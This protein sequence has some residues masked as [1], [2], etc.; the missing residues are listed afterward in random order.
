ML[1]KLSKQDQVVAYL[2]DYIEKHH[3]KSGD[4]L[5][6]EWELAEILNVSRTTIQGAFR[7]LVDNGMAYNKKGYG[8]YVNSAGK[9]ELSLPLVIADQRESTGGFEYVRGA[10]AYLKE[11]GGQL[12]TQCTNG[13]IEDEQRI[14]KDQ[15]EAGAKCILVL[16]ISSTKSGVFYQQ[17]ADQHGVRFIFLDKRPQG[18]NAD[19]VC[20][21]NVRGGYLAT[22]HLIKAGHTR[23]GFIS[24]SLYSAS[25]RM[26]RYIGYTMA[27]EAYGLT[28][29]PTMVCTNDA[30]ENKDTYLNMI[31]Q[32]NPPTAIFAVSDGLATNCIT[33]LIMNGYKV[34]EDISIIGF[35]GLPF[36]STSFLRL[37][38]I[39]QPFYEIGYQAAH[40]ACDPYI[41]AGETSTCLMLPVELLEQDT[42]KVVD[43]NHI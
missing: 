36:F 2:T 40:L 38:S 5:P 37:T 43:L 30:A 32:P 27:M 1:K 29:N 16:P 25:S 14:I 35:D 9:K 6:T 39:R 8:T 4:R 12:L 22:E 24:A 26:Q 23:I 7:K 20:C 28:V 18:V 33:T 21:D 10:Q 11:H 19:Y 41:K 3:L 34:P 31:R 42:V 13:H 17:M 15:I